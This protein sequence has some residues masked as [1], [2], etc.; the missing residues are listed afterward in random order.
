MLIDKTKVYLFTRWQ[1]YT[2]LEDVYISV[3]EKITF[4]VDLHLI[5]HKKIMLK[6]NVLFLSFVNCSKS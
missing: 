1:R 2:Y 3:S 4:D 6:V 5:S